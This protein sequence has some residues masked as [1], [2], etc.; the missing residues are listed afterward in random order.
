MSQ[1]TMNLKVK[2]WRQKNAN[3]QGAFVTYDVA[4]ISDEM[5]FFFKFI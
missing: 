2:V 4:G 5:S 1:N 3:A